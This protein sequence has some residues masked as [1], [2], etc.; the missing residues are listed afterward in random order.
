MHTGLETE[1]RT[2]IR[3]IPKRSISELLRMRAWR[4]RGISSGSAGESYAAA[5]ID[6][7]TRDMTAPMTRMARLRM[8]SGRAIKAI[9]ATHIAIEYVRGEFSF[10]ENFAT[11]FIL[12]FTFIVVLGRNRERRNAP[13][14]KMPMHQSSNSAESLSSLNLFIFLAFR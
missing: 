14:I 11:F 6:T 12:K 5:I 7:A 2:S 13:L 3:D 4:K 9:P 10:L 1:E 8:R